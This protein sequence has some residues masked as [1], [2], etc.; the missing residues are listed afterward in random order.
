MIKFSLLQAHREM[1]KYPKHLFITYGSYETNWW[2]T[3]DVLDCTPEERAEVLKY[4]L[5][6]LHYSHPSENYSIE[7][8]KRTVCNCFL[9][10]LIIII[11]HNYAECRMSLNLIMTHGIYVTLLALLPVWN[12][13]SI[14]LMPF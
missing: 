7:S 11:G 13:N 9:V 6:A 3:Q 14:V 12:L 10:D 5:A 2:A 8:C 1:L 4:S